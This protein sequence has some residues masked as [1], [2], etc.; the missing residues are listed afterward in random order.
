MINVLIERMRSGPLGDF[1]LEDKE[2]LFIKKEMKDVINN[3]EE[4]ENDGD[5]VYKLICAMFVCSDVPLENLMK[6]LKKEKV[7]AILRDEYVREVDWWADPEGF[8]FEDSNE[9]FLN[10]IS[11]MYYM[12]QEIEKGKTDHLFNENQLFEVLQNYVCDNIKERL[13]KDD[14]KLL[15]EDGSFL[16]P[17]LKYLKAI[18]KLNEFIDEWGKEIIN[19]KLKLINKK[20][21]EI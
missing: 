6:E 18:E 10:P 16:Y 7:I 13:N 8:N 20:V 15:I 21:E 11:N 4:G 3:Y 1:F 9:Y 5:D 12:I 2:A 19:E 14:E 17:Y